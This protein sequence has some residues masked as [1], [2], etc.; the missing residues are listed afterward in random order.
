MACSRRRLLGQ[1]TGLLLGGAARA[2]AAPPLVRVEEIDPTIATDLSYYKPDNVFGR[3]FYPSNVALLRRPVAERLAR[4]NAWLR[5]A[6]YRLLI[7]DAYRPRSIH[8]RMWEVAP[9]RRF[10]AH[11][12]RGS[13]HSRGAAVDVTLIRL[14]GSPVP[15]PTPHD[16]FTRRARRGATRG[17]SPEARR[18]W[19]RLDAAMRRAG[20]RPLAH[21][22]WHFDAPEARRYP[23]SDLPLPPE[24]PPKRR[25]SATLSILTE[26]T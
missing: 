17:V 24:S 13:N 8:R 6:G 7:W 5:R 9:D 15:M 21:E 20:F 25:D 16:E 18:N 26:T 1:I 12:R 19:A 3:R 4:A 11:P 10:L 14:D 22:W 2:A 23:L